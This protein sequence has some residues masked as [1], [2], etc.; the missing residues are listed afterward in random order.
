MQ[1][2]SG[3]SLNGVVSGAKLI[4]DSLG[5]PLAA[6]LFDGVT[7]TFES[8][9]HPFSILVTASIVA[10]S[11]REQSEIRSVSLSPMAAGRIAGKSPY[12]GGKLRWTQKILRR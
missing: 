3:H 8:R 1:D 2:I 4:A 7:I 5:Q 6:F 11:N 10:S 12:S 9:I